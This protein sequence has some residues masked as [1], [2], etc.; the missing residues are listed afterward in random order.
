MKS[1][2]IAFKPWNCPIMHG[3][4]WN[5]ILRMGC[6]CNRHHSESGVSL[7]AYDKTSHLS[8][9]LFLHNRRA[10]KNYPWHRTQDR[11]M[12]E[13]RH[14][15]GLPGSLLR[16]ADRLDYVGRSAITRVSQNRSFYTY[17]YVPCTLYPVP[18]RD[19]ITRPTAP[20]AEPI[21]LDHAARAE[22]FFLRGPVRPFP[23]AGS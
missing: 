3:H 17:T 22:S 2:I 19:S 4:E 6:Q 13:Q 11:G 8:D 9:S 20:Q 10:K 18:L 16:Q 12:H 14:W 1:R 5:C 21:P 23:E 15:R 7:L